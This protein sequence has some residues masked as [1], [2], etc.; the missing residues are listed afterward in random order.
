[1]YEDKDCKEILDRLYEDNLDELAKSLSEETHAKYAKPE[2][3]RVAAYNNALKYAKKE[4]K[5][6]IYGY[7]QMGDGKFFA[8]EQPI[9][10]SSSPAEAE[11]EFKN[12]YKRCSTVYTVYPDKDFVD[13]SLEEE[14]INIDYVVSLF[15]DDSHYYKEDDVKL[16]PDISGA[17][18]FNKKKDISILDIVKDICE[19]ESK[20]MPENEVA[21][22]FDLDTVEEVYEKDED[23]FINSGLVKIITVYKNKKIN[24]PESLKEDTVIDDFPEPEGEPMSDKELEEAM[25]I[26]E[27]EEK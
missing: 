27:P 21:S 16:S 17:T 9:K 26:K 3:D 25:G 7:S 5:P 11:E 13:E 8:L 1:M 4:N 6:F 15:G 14:K 2:G 10:I 23:Y 12:K 24:L 20:Y 22:L 19:Y 18:K